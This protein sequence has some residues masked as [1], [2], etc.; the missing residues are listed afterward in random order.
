MNKQKTLRPALLLLGS[1][2]LLQGCG[3]DDD[4]DDEPVA[5]SYRVSITNLTAAQPLSPPLL[6]LHEGDF[7]FFEIGSPATPGFEEMAEGGSTTLLQAEAEADDGVVSTVAGSA[8]IGPGGS[9]DFTITA[10]VSQQTVGLS[11]AGMLV[12]TN[13]AVSGVNAVDISNLAIDESLFLNA[14]AYDAGTEANSEA[15]GS[16]P[17][18]ADGGEGF[19]ALRDD[20]ADQVTMHSG[21]VTSDDGL[22]TSV[23][24]DIHRFLNPTL[25]ITIERVE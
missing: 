10:D 24:T 11:L 19:N 16:I 18:P 6:V 3:S 25:R 7:Q 17:G 12:N 1:V 4:S 9:D 13:D 21:V 14:I 15:A 23:L 2:F 20:R 8:P 5:A 22:M